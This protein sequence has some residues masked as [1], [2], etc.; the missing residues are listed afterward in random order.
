MPSDFQRRIE[1]QKANMITAVKKIAARGLVWGLKYIQGEDTPIVNP[2][3][4]PCY[5][6]FPQE[7]IRFFVGTK[8]GLLY[9][10]GDRLWKLFEGRVYGITQYSGR[11]YTTWNH[12]VRLGKKPLSTMASIISFRFDDE[13]VV[14]LRAEAAPLDQSVHQ[15]DAW[16]NHLFVTDTA[17]NRVLVYR[18]ESDGLSH[19]HAHYP[20][21]YLRNGRRSDNYAHINS[22]FKIEDKILL[23]YH[24]DSE[25]TGKNSEIVEVSPDFKPQ[26]R[27]YLDA[28]CA[29]NIFLDGENLVYC[30]SLNGEFRLG[31]RLIFKAPM[32]FRGL[33][34]TQKYWILGASK[35][36]DRQNRDSTTG[37]IYTLD[38][39][40][41]ELLSL[42][43]IPKSGS[44][45][46]IR[47]I[48]PE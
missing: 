30:D 23:M 13:L 32:F 35:L 18:I 39:S 6:M 27:I 22:I 34:V 46:E 15:I 16:D 47:L 21:G 48:E 3:V 8:T 38:R 20:N 31:D 11:W 2:T 29:H 37:H 12:K 5:G 26:N 7:K 33:G 1:E 9:F 17:N 28:R 25:N 40:S 45:Y 36:A 44:I 19:L 43:Q 42:L 4:V 24:N 41:N 14:D 10:D